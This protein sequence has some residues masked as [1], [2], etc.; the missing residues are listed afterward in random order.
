MPEKS[1][2]PRIRTVGFLL[3][4]LVLIYALFQL[5]SVFAKDVETSSLS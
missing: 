1:K 5:V 4:A 2:N 3:I